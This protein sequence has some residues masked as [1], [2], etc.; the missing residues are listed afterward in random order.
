MRSDLQIVHLTEVPEVVPTLV[1]WFTA[2]WAPWYGPEGEGNVE[3]DLAA[4]L[5][6]QAL[7]ICL[8][9]FDK[10]KQMVGTASLKD[11]SVGSEY[12][13]GPWLAGLLVG[14]AFRRAGVGSAL[15]A[16]IE[17]EAGRLELEQIP[18]IRG[19]IR[20]QRSSFDTR[21]A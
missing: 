1:D 3:A 5:N 15:V 19:H 4:C 16:A 2:E 10:S 6:R 7:P 11:D 21:W 17:S 9:A 8:V 20:Q 18:I 13:V 12:G 14:G